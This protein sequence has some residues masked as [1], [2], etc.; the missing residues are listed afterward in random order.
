MP[1]IDSG[2]GWLLFKLPPGELGV[3]PAG[4]TELA[5]GRHEVYFTCDDIGQTVAELEAKGVEFTEA[6]TETSFGHLTRFKVPGGGEIGLYE[7]KHSSAYDL[8][9]A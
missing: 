2:G 7:P 9:D 6:V 1:C 3:H 8:P 4:P 5:G